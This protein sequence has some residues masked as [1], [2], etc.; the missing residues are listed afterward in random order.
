MDDELDESVGLNQ[1]GFTWIC[2][3]RVETT[4]RVHGGD[5]VD[6]KKNDL[7]VEF[8]GTCKLL[9]LGVI[10][11]RGLEFNRYEIYLSSERRWKSKR[12]VVVVGRGVVQTWGW[13]SLKGILAT[14]LYLA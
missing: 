14:N 13:P 7:R 5:G 8:L 3:F 1:C 6:N 11:R 10:S 12:I 9:I 4:P 2:R